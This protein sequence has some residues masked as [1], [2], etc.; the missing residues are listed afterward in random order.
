MYI[1]LEFVS[2]FFGYGRMKGRLNLLVFN[3]ISY[4]FDDFPSS[5]SFLNSYGLNL[6]NIFVDL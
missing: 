1:I 2:P 4:I 5:N 3:I 6:L